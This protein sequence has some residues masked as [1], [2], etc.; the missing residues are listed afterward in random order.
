MH[1]PTIGIIT[2]VLLATAAV[3]AVFPPENE[4]LMPACLR[5]GLVMAALWMAQPE[6]VRLPPWLMAGAVVVILVTALRPRLFLVAVVVLVAVAILRPR[7][8]AAKRGR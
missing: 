1:R 7:R 8:T 4:A 6:L 2:I 3:L 5:V